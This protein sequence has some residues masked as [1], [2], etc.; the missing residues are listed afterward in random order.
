MVGRSLV[1]VSA[2]RILRINGVFKIAI[3]LVVERFLLDW[4]QV[5]NFVWVKIKSV[6]KAHFVSLVILSIL[7]SQKLALKHL[8]G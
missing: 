6:I 1:I 5:R 8:L 3:H 2:W 7:T 4:R